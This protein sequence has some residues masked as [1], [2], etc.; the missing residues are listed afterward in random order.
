MLLYYLS[1]FRNF[2]KS[3]LVIISGLRKFELETILT[4]F[5]HNP[6]I[7]LVIRIC[8]KEFIQ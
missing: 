2:A 4:S 6:F 1:Q 7:F 5:T 3:I 8:F